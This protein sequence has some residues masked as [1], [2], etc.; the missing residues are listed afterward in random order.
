MEKKKAY[1]CKYTSNDKWEYTGGC[2]IVFA[3]SKQG[4]KIEAIKLA[5]ENDA[6]HEDYEMYHVEKIKKDTN[7]FIQAPAID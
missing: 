3:N 2:V 4:A 6:W 5:R 7:I 1:L